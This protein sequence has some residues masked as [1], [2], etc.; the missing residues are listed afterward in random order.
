MK[1]G[2]DLGTEHHSLSG[3][4]LSFQAFVEE[5]TEKEGHPSLRN[6]KSRTCRDF[7]FLRCLAQSTTCMSKHRVN[8]SGVGGEVGL[9]HDVVSIGAGYIGQ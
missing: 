4:A 8:L 2:N 9:A 1:R 5:V 3:T 6:E 7:S